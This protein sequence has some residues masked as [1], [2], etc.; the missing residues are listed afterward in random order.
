MDGNERTL[1]GNA[2]GGLLAEI[3][4]FEMTMVQA[5]CAGCGS[6]DAVGAQTAYMDAPGLVIRCAN[7]ESV[8]I[9]V[10]HGGGR[11]WLDLR[12]VNCLQIDERTP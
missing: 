2:A 3:F 1:D 4:P 6:M 10:V 9:R 8:L 11:Y 7:C 12:G 5:W